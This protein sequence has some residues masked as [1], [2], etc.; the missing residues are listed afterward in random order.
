MHHLTKIAEPRYCISQIIFD[1]YYYMNI[2]PYIYCG[3]NP[4]VLKGRFAISILT[5]A[6]LCLRVE[7]TPV[8]L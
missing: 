7:M 8:A 1:N 5:I 6:V 3:L 2:A 4:P